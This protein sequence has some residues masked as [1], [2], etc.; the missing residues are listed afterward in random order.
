MHE[1]SKEQVIHA[2]AGGPG[3]SVIVECMA[4]RDYFA[5]ETLK[6]LY[7]NA[8]WYAA[9]HKVSENP[10][11]F[12]ATMADEAYKQADDMIDRRDKKKDD[13]GEPSEP[14]KDPG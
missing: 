4:L 5:G 7:A 11:V 12:R 2:G 10:E 14:V 13:A 6:G 1:A 3:G 9:C 8:G